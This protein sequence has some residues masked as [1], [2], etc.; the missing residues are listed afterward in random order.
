MPLSVLIAWLPRH[1][2]PP[3]QPWWLEEISQAVMQLNLS[4]RME[5]GVGGA[6]QH[7]ALGLLKERVGPLRAQRAQQPQAH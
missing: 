2:P 3:P 6:I 4:A 7:G 1:H 5:G